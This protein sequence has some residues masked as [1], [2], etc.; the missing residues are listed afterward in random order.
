MIAQFGMYSE[1]QFCERLQCNLLF[2]CFRDLNGTDCRF[3]HSVFSKDRQRLLDSDTAREFLLAIEQRAWDG[4]RLPEGH[5]CVDG[6]PL[7]AGLS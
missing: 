4:R 2:D 5:F 6:T 3:D 1:S 7:N